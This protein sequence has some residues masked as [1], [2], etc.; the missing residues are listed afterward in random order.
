MDPGAAGEQRGAGRRALGVHSAAAAT[1]VTDE[2]AG[3]VLVEGFV[4]LDATALGAR[5][6][7]GRRARREHRADD[8][9]SGHPRMHDQV[10]LVPL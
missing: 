4:V 6:W 9:A 8:D 5:S 10:A 1:V 3:A 2:L 7:C